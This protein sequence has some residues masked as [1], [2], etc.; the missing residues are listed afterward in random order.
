MELPK[1]SRI[2][3]SGHNDNM[4]LCFDKTSGKRTEWAGPVTLKSHAEFSAKM[5]YVRWKQL[6]G[7]RLKAYVLTARSHLLINTHGGAVD[8]SIALWRW[9][10]APMLPA[11][12]VKGASR[13]GVDGGAYGSVTQKGSIIFLPG[14]PID[15]TIITT[16][17]T[18]HVDGAVNPIFFPA[19]KAGSRFLIGLVGSGDEN[20]PDIKAVLDAWGLGAKTTAGFGWVLVEPYDD[21]LCEEVKRVQE[22]KER[23]I[24]EAMKTKAQSLLELQKPMLMR[25]VAASQNAWALAANK[26]KL[27]DISD[28][29]KRDFLLYL[30]SQPNRWWDLL[31]NMKKEGGKEK[32][33]LV[34]EIAEKLGVV[35]ERKL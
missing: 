25:G 11:S 6:W 18:S 22:A 2:A 1:D 21:E 9:C 10:G 29:D 13:H 17:I 16:G 28:D 26:L 5:R 20:F 8:H 24:E 30:F 14:L 4:S 33:R 31:G 3:L 15:A 19:I 7:S 12:G 35:P 32:Y 23:R 34:L 27:A